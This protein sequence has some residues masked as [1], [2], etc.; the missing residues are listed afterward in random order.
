[1][2]WVQSFYKVCKSLIAHVK[3]YHADGM[4][5]NKDG[6][7]PEE[8]VKSASEGTLLAESSSGTPKAQEGASSGGPPPPPPLPT[9]DKAPPPSSTGSKSSSAG[10]M[11]AIFN[12]INRGQSVTSGLRKVDK[13]EMTHKNPSLRGSN[14]IPQRGDMAVGQGKAERVRKMGP[15]RKELEG[16]KWIIENFED[17]QQPVEVEAQIQHSILISK[18]RKTILRIKGK[19]NAISLDNCERTSLIV[20]SLVSSVDVIKS[21]GFALQVLGTVPT[22]MLDQVDGGTIY[23]NSH[24]LDT[25]VFTSKCSSVNV[26]MPPKDENDDY[27]ECPLPEQIRSYIKDGRMISDIVEHAG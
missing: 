23:L 20:D 24:S 8:A 6:M 4:Q 16:N 25:E 1:M 21:P 27:R 13:A 2:E 18:C 9:F 26:N 22:I 19:A 11:G 10:D 17:P 14:T 7:E 12:Q 3:Q 5:W 15:P